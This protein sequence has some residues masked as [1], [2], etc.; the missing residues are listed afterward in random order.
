MLFERA[1]RIIWLIKPN[2]RAALPAIKCQSFGGPNVSVQ[3]STLN[4]AAHLKYWHVLEVP[5]QVPEYVTQESVY[6]IKLDVKP[7][8]NVIQSGLEITA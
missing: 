1:S 2:P 5:I 6:F 3:Y 8:E 4:H 7:S